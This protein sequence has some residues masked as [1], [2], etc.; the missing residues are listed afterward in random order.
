MQLVERPFP[1]H[2][3]LNQNSRSS[4]ILYM[5]RTLAVV[6][7]LACIIFI[8]ANASTLKSYG[9]PYWLWKAALAFHCT[10]IIYNIFTISYTSP[11]IV[12][13]VTSFHIIVLIPILAMIAIGFKIPVLRLARMR[14]SEL[15]EWI[16]VLPL[17][18]CTILI[19]IGSSIFYFVLRALWHRHWL[20]T[21]DRHW[22]PEKSPWWWKPLGIRQ[23][24]KRIKGHNSV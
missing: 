11:F 1:R 10:H 18:L 5:A 16:V 7:P 20:S 3:Y 13:I 2:G 14:I 15:E 4:P 12:L 8:C 23:L 24:F 19:G 22:R 6:P 21:F 17:C 9:N